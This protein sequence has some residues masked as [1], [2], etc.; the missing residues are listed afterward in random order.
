MSKLLESITLAKEL[1]KYGVMNENKFIEDK[2]L[3]LITSLLLLKNEPSLEKNHKNSIENEIIRVKRKVPKWFDKA[4]QYN[5]RILLSYM[6][7]SNCNQVSIDINELMSFTGIEEKIFFG[8][9]NNMKIISEKN[10]AKVFEEVNKRVLLWKPIATIVSAYYREET[11]RIWAKKGG[12]MTNETVVEQ[13]ILLL[14]IKIPKFL[15]EINS[16]LQYENLFLC[17]DKNI[18]QEL[19]LKFLKNG[20]WHGQMHGTCPSAIKK[21]MDFL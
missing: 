6:K 16:E 17:E 13:Y 2:S 8:H 4:T 15:K 20:E 18:L 12:K 3:T 19:H 21:Y 11:F 7:L 5:S 14:K 10:H 9:Y 1:Y